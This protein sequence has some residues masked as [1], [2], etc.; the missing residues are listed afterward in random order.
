MHT[1]YFK[2]TFRIRILKLCYLSLLSR[3][4]SIPQM[5][6]VANEQGGIKGKS[7]DSTDRRGDSMVNDMLFGVRV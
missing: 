6:A 3:P 2:Q 7:T 4:P 1:S 5:H